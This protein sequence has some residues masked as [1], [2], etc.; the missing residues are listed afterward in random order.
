MTLFCIWS[1]ALFSEGGWNLNKCLTSTRL[2]LIF[3]GDTI[4]G[5][6]NL[7]LVF[8]SVLSGSNGTEDLCLQ[9][10]SNRTKY[11]HFC[12]KISPNHPSGYLVM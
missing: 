6:E 12:P 10:N 9:G 5:A 2:F 1:F 8:L 3:M 11:S 7:K 4:T